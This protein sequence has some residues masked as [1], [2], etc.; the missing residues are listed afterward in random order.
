VEAVVRLKPDATVG[1]VIRLELDAIF[2]G[3][4]RL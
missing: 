3:G 1:R 2:C 4:V